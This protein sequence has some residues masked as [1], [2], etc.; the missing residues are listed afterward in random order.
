MKFYLGTHKAAWLAK[1]G[2]PLFVSRR[3]LA[4]RRSLPRAIAPW[5]LDS[6]GFTELN[7]KG[8]WDLSPRVY[9]QEVR[10][11][12]DE[13]GMM[14]WAAPQDWM[15]EPDIR[16]KSGLSTRHHQMYTLLNYVTL[17]NLA[18]DLPW[19]PVLQGWTLGDYI[20][21]IEMYLKAGIDLTKED[22]VGVGS[23]C[24]RQGTIRSS[25]LFAWLADERLKLHG[26]GVKISGLKTYRQHVVSADSMA[27]SYHARKH[28]PLPGHT[29]KSCANCME[30]AL[31]WRKKHGL[32]DE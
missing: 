30:Y 18:P 15:C 11:F 10:R 7:R 19:I 1:A 31:L 3:T 6:G 26:F 13:I 24:R 8:A 23:V 12:R 32:D 20:E 28:P 5:A 21:H 17:L 14:E 9:A 27:W 4:P 16:L 25:L 22:V 29:H 2:V